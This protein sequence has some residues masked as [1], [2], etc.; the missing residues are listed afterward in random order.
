MTALALWL[1]LYPGV[2]CALIALLGPAIL[3]E[4]KR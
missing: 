4:V 2:L 3:R 1:A